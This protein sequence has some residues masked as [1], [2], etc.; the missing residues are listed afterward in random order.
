[1]PLRISL[2]S[3]EACR[4][5]LLSFRTLLS[6]NRL[7]SLSA[8]TSGG[9][10]HQGV[11]SG[12]RCEYVPVRPTKSSLFLPIQEGRPWRSPRYFCVCGPVNRLSPLSSLP[13]PS[14]LQA[15][16]PSEAPSTLPS[17]SPSQP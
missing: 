2:P 1:M 10:S 15:Q 5:L 14:L 3:T 17:R 6:I 11:P 7:N 4:F 8:P 16:T 12:L 13:T 9:V